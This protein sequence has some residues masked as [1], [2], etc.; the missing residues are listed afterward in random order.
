MFGDVAKTLIRML[1]AGDL[2]PNAIGA[3]DVAITLN[4]LREQLRSHAELEAAP[5]DKSH[6]GEEENEGAPIVSLSMRAVPLID[7]LER[8]ASAK[9]PVMWEKME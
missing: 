2:L 7:M 8:A 9:A 1:G 4:R 3:D 6:D 5:S